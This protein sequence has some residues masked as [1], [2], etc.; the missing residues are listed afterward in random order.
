MLIDDDIVRNYGGYQC[1]N[2]HMHIW[3]RILHLT[4]SGLA[5]GSSK[6]HKVVPDCEPPTGPNPPVQGTRLSA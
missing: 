3:S 5:S 4:P 2:I 6:S 1:L